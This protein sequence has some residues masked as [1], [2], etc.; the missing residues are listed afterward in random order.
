MQTRLAAVAL[1]LIVPIACAH[2][3]NAELRTG[4]AEIELLPPPVRIAPQGHEPPF[5]PELGP[6]ELR[7]DLPAYP[8]SALGDAVACTARLLYHIETDGSASLVRLEWDEPPP[9]EHTDAF[10]SAIDAA[11]ARWEFEPGRRWIKRTQPDGT[12][13][14]E[15]QLIPKSGRALIRFRV[16]DGKPVVD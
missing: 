14:R 2:R 15:M 10:V 12:S 16:D 7:Q 5:R 6:I 9:P 3:G 11:M 4:A 13:K 8:L 1:L